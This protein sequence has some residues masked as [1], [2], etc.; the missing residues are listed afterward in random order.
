[1]G[2]RGK[3]KRVLRFV[4]YQPGCGGYLILG[5]KMIDRL[6]GMQERDMRVK[7]WI[8]RDSLWYKGRR[9]KIRI[10]G[11]MGGFVRARDSLIS[12]AILHILIFVHGRGSIEKK[13]G[14]C[15]CGG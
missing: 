7:K 8:G 10:N 13:R 1:M 4:K 14:V 11:V 2:N 15:L 9:E 5:Q 6:E 3:G 12:S